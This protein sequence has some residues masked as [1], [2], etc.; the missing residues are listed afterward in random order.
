MQYR[1]DHQHEGEQRR[2][3]GG[4]RDAALVGERAARDVAVFAGGGDEQP[5]KHVDSRAE[6]ADQRTAHERC[7][8]DVGADTGSRADG[9]RDAA[10]EPP[11]LRPPERA[12]RPLHRPASAQVRLPAGAPVGPGPWPVAVAG[13]V[14]PVAAAAGDRVRR[15]RLRA[16]GPWW[17]AELGVACGRGSWARGLRRG[18]GAAGTPSWSAAWSA[19]GWSAGLS[20]AAARSPFHHRP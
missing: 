15:R 3:A 11:L 13:P 5:G 18:F 9:S 20:S 12:A 17:V 6:P 7:A 10:D 16:P 8:D 2:C 4:E 19:A 14:S 1:G